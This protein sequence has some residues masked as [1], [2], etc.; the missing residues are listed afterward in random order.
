[1]EEGFKFRRVNE[2]TGTF[3]LIVVAVVIAAVVW[4]SHSQRWF[5]S[6][7]NLQIVLPEAGAAGIRQGSEV[8]FLGTL[9]GSVS[10]VEVDATGRMEAEA[11]IRRDFFRF[12]RADSSAVVKKKFGLAG[13]SYF[14]IS[15][16]QGQPLPE[17]NASIDCRELPAT[18]ES[19]IEEVRSAALPVLQKMS[20]GLDTWTA[21]GTNLIATQERLEQLIGRLN[22]MVAGVEQGKGTAGKLITD[23]ALADEAQNLLAQANRIMGELQNVTTNLNAAVRNVQSGTAR[24][25]EI[26]GSVADGT[27]DLPGLV[28]QTKVSM[29]EIERVVEAMQRTWL[30]RSH[31]NWTNPPPLNPP[32][33]P[34][35]PVKKP[36]R[37]LHSPRDSAK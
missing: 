27:K 13:D 5:K 19:A 30:L 4:T 29:R 6:N 18:M 22:D 25:P 7:V 12:V 23:P 35:P 16:G 11:D 20:V 17:K 21:L 31:V 24:L 10:Y 26:T 28:R 8:Y 32:S 2:I 34:A 3:V 1:M 37:V 36:T 15:R 14:E 9:V 33:E